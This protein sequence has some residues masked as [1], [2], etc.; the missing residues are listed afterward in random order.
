MKNFKN[1]DRLIQGIESIISENRCSLSEEDILLLEECIVEFSNTKIKGSEV[2][3]T[4][5][6]KLSEL[7]LRVFM[8]ENTFKQVADLFKF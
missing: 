7:F 6:V 3:L 4:Q 5:L 2:K 8:D 1:V